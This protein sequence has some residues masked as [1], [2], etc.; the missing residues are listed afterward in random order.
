MSSRACLG[1]RRASSKRISARH[2]KCSTRITTDWRRSRTGSSNI[3]PSRPAPTRSKVRSCA[4]SARPALAKPVSA[5]R[6]P[7]PPGASSSASRSAGSATRPRSAAIAAPIS[8]R[9][10]A[11]SSPTSRRP[12]SPTRCSCST[13]STSSARISAGIRHRRCSRCSTPSRTASSRTTISNST[14]ICRT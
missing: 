5:S 8:V 1:A 11:R 13:R 9:C 4:S 7:A 6:S 12:A 2:S 10:R 3:S 14:S